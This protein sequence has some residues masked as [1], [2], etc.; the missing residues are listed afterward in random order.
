MVVV[1]VRVAL[2]ESKVLLR[3]LWFTKVEMLNIGL[4]PDSGSHGSRKSTAVVWGVR[5]CDDNDG[6]DRGGGDGDVSGIVMA[7]FIVI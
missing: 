1:V 2:G 6:D 4:G 3:G 5:V 7:I